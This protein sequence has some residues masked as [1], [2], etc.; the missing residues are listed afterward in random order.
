MTDTT[1]ASE[2]LGTQ[3]VPK[4]TEQRIH[5]IILPS[6]YTVS[7][8]IL[9]LN[10]K[11]LVYNTPPFHSEKGTQ[12]FPDKTKLRKL[13][14]AQKRQEMEQIF[15]TASH[16]RNKTSF[17]LQREFFLILFNMNKGVNNPMDYFL[18]WIFSTTIT[19]RWKNNILRIHTIYIY[20]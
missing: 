18:I 6:P 11:L 17:Y 9:A 12:K 13:D 14:Q 2:I 5:M 4:Y 3:L 20:C 1:T 15:V 10:L 8:L 19:E 7:S 16:D